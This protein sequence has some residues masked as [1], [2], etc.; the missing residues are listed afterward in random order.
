[1]ATCPHLLP[2]STSRH[3]Q[4]QAVEDEDDLPLPPKKGWSRA[5]V[6][7]EEE[8]DVEDDAEPPQDDEFNDPEDEDVYNSA[9][10]SDEAEETD[11]LLLASMY[12]DSHRYSDDQY[13]YDVSRACLFRRTLC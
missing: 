7:D 1:M 10:N 3:R 8:G 11:A 12:Q 4:Q 9:Y 2:H 6:E 5:T 13:T